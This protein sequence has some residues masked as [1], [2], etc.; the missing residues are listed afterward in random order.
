[1]E[2]T[3]NPSTEFKH[4]LN[5]VPRPITGAA[6][7]YGKREAVMKTHSE[8]TRQE[9]FRALVEAQD[10]GV[11]VEESR[12]HVARQFTLSASDLL[13]IEKEGISKTWPPL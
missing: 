9:V 13:A 7:F 8:E 11:T 5:A 4:R 12:M 10:R 2:G 3:F 6:L 1:M